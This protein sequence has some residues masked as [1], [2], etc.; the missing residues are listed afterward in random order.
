MAQ[1][2]GGIILAYLVI[3]HFSMVFAV[4]LVVAA[5]CWTINLFLWLVSKL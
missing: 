1:V 5:I 4:V 3:F 2:A